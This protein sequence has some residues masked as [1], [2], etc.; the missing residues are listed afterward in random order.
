MITHNITFCDPPP[1]DSLHAS[2][3]FPFESYSNADDENKK[4][5]LF[6]FIREKLE[7]RFDPPQV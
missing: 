3:S 6:R 2:N 4:Q 5:F 1:Q 7:Q